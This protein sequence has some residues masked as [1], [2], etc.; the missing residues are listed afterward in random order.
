VLTLLPSFSVSELPSY[1][2]EQPGWSIEGDKVQVPAN[3]DNDVKATVIR[4]DLQLDRES[5]LWLRDD[6][7]LLTCATSPLRAHKVPV[8]STYANSPSVKKWCILSLI[9]TFHLILSKVLLPP[10]LKECA[11]CSPH[12]FIFYLIDQWDIETLSHRA[13][14]PGIVTT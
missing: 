2:E 7:L 9:C 11:F 10:A 14:V 3:P 1:I 5:A 6:S 8:T 12:P 4:E 13:G